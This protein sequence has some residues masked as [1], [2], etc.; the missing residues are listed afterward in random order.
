MKIIKNHLVTNAK[1][2]QRRLLMKTGLIYNKGLAYMNWVDNLDH[3]GLRLLTS[4][5]VIAGVTVLAVYMICSMV[6]GFG[7]RFVFNRSESL[8]YNRMM[9]GM[10]ALINIV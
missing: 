6:V 2:Y 4:L 7:A 1:P 8:V 5:P 9:N 10:D 3:L